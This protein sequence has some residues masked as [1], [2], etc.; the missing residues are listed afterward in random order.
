M[1]I[2]MC[3]TGK[4]KG[5]TTSALGCCVRALGHDKKV[6]VLQ[7]IKHDV[8]KYGEYK[9][10]TSL[11]CTWKSYGQG[12]TWMQHSLDETKKLCNEGWQFFKHCYEDGKYDL[13]VLDELTYTFSYK[14]LDE[15][16]VISFFNEKKGLDSS[17]MV[18]ITGRGASEALLDVCDTVSEIED[19]KHHYRTL[20]QYA[21]KMI[22]F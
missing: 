18:I 4:G 17:P 14:L 16:D 7:F 2:L 21:K 15:K 19:I 20:G 10:L 12:F 11:G 8:E 22:E 6:A 1:G 3:I 13:I 5:K 9:C